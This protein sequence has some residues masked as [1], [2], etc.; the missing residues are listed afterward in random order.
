MAIT[1]LQKNKNKQK[2]MIFVLIF[3][4]L[5]IAVVVW[6]GFF[7]DKSSELESSQ[8]FTPKRVNINWDTLKNEKL[9]AFYPFKG[10]TPFEGESKRTNP[11]IPY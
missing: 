9:E 6:W 7:R 2:L 3:V 5:V 1:F 11:F 4:V 10:I 8:T